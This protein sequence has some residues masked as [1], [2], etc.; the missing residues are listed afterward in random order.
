MKIFIA[1]LDFKITAEQ[2]HDMF[3]VFGTITDC[4]LIT[5]QNLNGKSKG[6]GFVC[7]SEDLYAKWAIKAM[8]GIEINHRALVVR[9]AKSK[10][11][12]K[13]SRPKRPRIVTNDYQPALR[14][15]KY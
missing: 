10:S 9:E 14:D 2:L 8:N 15:I 11:F 7:F 5:E 6:Y 1:N 12:E 4:K 3:L 13:L